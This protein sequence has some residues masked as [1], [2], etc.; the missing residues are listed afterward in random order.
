MQTK[1]TTD[2]MNDTIRAWVDAELPRPAGGFE[3]DEQEQAWEDATG[4][5]FSEIVNMPDAEF[6][7]LYAAKTGRTLSAMNSDGSYCES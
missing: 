6:R 5:R 4:K 2:E 1:I 3:T 7:S